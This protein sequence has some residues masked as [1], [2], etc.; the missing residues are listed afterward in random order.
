MSRSKLIQYTERAESSSPVAS[1]APIDDLP[2]LT[3]EKNAALLE[4][5]HPRSGAYS[6]AQA[7]LDFY[8]VVNA[9]GRAFVLLG[10]LLMGAAVLRWW[11]DRRTTSGELR[12]EVSAS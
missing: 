4:R 11:R 10:L 2:H 9:G 12:H 1:I 3:P 5:L 6:F 7:K 8:R